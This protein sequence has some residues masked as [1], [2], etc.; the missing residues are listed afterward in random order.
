MS[1]ASI[2]RIR[3]THWAWGLH[4]LLS[5]QNECSLRMTVAL[6]L[7][8]T[9]PKRACRAHAV[10]SVVEEFYLVDP[11]SSHMLVS[12]IKP[13]MCKYEQIQTVKLRV[14]H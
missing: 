5:A 7:E 2:S 12:K 14:A 8:L 3:Y 11:A 4:R 13:C 1:S 6:T 9:L 10:R